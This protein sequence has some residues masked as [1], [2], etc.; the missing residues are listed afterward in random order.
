SSPNL[1]YGEDRCIKSI[2]AVRMNEITSGKAQPCPSGRLLR[3]KNA[4]NALEVGRNLH[5][6]PAREKFLGAFRDGATHFHHQPA[7][8]LEGRKSLGNKAFDDFQTRFAGKHGGSWLEF[9]DF[10]LN[11]VLLGKAD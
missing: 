2:P 9:A 5:I 6:C 11:L 3:R 7:A 4:W 8:G 10:Q 1:V